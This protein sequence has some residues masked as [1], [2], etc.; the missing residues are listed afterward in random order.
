MKAVS[1]QPVQTKYSY[2]QLGITNTFHPSF[3]PSF[4]RKYRTVDRWLTTSGKKKHPLGGGGRVIRKS[5]RTSRDVEEEN[6]SQ[7]LVVRVGYLRARNPL[8]AGVEGSRHEDVG[9]GE[10]TWSDVFRA[11]DRDGDASGSSENRR[12]TLTPS[13]LTR[14][15]AARPYLHKAQ[16]PAGSF[17]TDR[18]KVSPRVASER[19]GRFANCHLRVYWSRR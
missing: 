6:T 10:E 5:R 15:A 12:A 18:P 2:R 7:S 14:E 9:K 8:G 17:A 19:K 11:K 16:V 1:R 4:R 13:G 3:H